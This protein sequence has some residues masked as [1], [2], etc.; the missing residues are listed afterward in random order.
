MEPTAMNPKMQSLLNLCKVAL[1][2]SNEQTLKGVIDFDDMV[3]QPLFY[4]AKFWPK[5]FVLVDEAQD[6]NPARRILAIRMAG[7]NGR[8]FVVGD[9]AQAIYGFTGADSDSMDLVKASLGSAEL[10]LN[11]TYRCPKSV[12]AIAQQWVPDFQAHETNPEGL[13]R[14]L[15]LVAELNSEGE[16]TTLDFSDEQ[17]T[18]ED[19][20]LCRNTKPLVELAW[21]LIRRGV[22][23]RVE[24]REIGQGLIT[25][26]KRWKVV[27][28]DAFKTKVQSWK[29]R[30]VAKYV[31]KGKEDMVQ[32]V[33]DKADTIVCIIDALM[34][35]GKRNVSDFEIF[36]NNLFGDTKEGEAPQVL[37][38]STVH[39]SK[40]R[41]WKRVYILG[42]NKYMPS[43]YAKKEWQVQQERNLMYVAVTRSMNELV[44]LSVN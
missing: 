16:K 21:T 26:A 6:L 25:M 41:E 42:M 17:L 39:K 37:T 36:V 30:E 12:V 10:P 33:V 27:R 28:L 34:A 20:V 11:L 44:F 31:S 8:I 14:Y 1:K 15:P 43:R 19:A 3:Y 35:D 29:D 2:R 22:A 38:L 4:R 5:D 13:V 9:P 7:P 23:C 24:G 40:G 18:K 32:G